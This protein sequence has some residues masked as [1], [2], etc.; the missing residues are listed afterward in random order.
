VDKSL[1]QAYCM[2]HCNDDFKRCRI[3]S[4]RRVHTW[5]CGWR[6]KFEMQG[7]IGVILAG[8]SLAGRTLTAAAAK[9]RPVKAD[10]RETEVASG[11]FAIKRETYGVRCH[12]AQS[13]Q[14]PSEW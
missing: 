8:Q 11:K 13:F 4:E 10:S 7:W 12:M 2:P 1:S 6:R 14:P 9:G 3:A 5:V